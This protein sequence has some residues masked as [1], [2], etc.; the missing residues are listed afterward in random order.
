LERLETGHG[1]SSSVTYD[2]HGGRTV[3]YSTNRSNGENHTVVYL[4]LR[5]LVNTNE[6]W[7]VASVQLAD[8]TGNSVPS[9]SMSW[10][11]G[12]SSIAFMPSLWPGEPA[13]KLKV[14]IKRTEGFR[15][16]EIFSFK[17]VPLGELGRTNIYDWSTNVAG[18]TVTLQSIFRQAPITNDSWSDSLMS[19]V[20]F[21][22]SSLPAGTQL[23]LLRMVFDT[24][25]TNQPESWSSGGNNREYSSRGFP[26]DAR[27]VDFTFAIQQSR[28][29]EFTVKPELPKERKQKAGTGVQ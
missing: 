27:T 16:E 15:P 9:S 20:H 14:E 11:G 17:N 24:G 13:W 28:T 5:P 10:N 25:K 1:N 29:V 26:A 8:A 22:L 21:S 18:V 23:D 4:Q 12:V 3:E 2:Q 19:K 6:L 7:Q